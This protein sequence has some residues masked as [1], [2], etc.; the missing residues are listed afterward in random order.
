MPIKAHA[1]G[2]HQVYLDRKKK[3]PPK[4]KGFRSAAYTSKA[5]TIKSE[6]LIREPRILFV[7][8]ETSP[9]VT[10]AWSRWKAN[11][12]AV[13]EESFVM[14]VAWRWGHEKRTHVLDLPDFPLYRHD[15]KSDRELVEHVHQLLSQSDI[16]ISHNGDRFDI[17]VLLGRM[18]VHEIPPP[19][20]FKSVD[21]LKLSR[22][23]RFSSHSLQEIS[24]LFNL[25]E[26]KPHDGID[27]WRRA[28]EG[29]AK[30]W[31]IMR[32]YCAHDVTLLVKLYERLR[33]YAK[34]HPDLSWWSRKEYCPTCRSY[35]IEPGGWHKCRLHCLSCGAW[36]SVTK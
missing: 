6:P 24:K 7:D 11:A 34:S 33:G 29:D 20:P 12:A 35:D 16:V 2:T 8:I 21:T 19:P 28:I 10:L 14:V 15:K 26:K 36:W 22:R 5:D 18:A 1:T 27:T 13:L 3:A 4:K 23:F 9:L 30:A 25:G 32:E 31:R 17:K